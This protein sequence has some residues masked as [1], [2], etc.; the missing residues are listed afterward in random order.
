MQEGSTKTS[1]DGRRQFKLT[2][3]IGLGGFGEVYLAEMSTSSGFTKTVALKLLRSD[4]EGAGDNAR[5]MRDEA[6][7][8]GL[9]RHRAIVQADDLITV[10][11][12][13]AVIME[14]I[15]GANLSDILDPARFP[16]AVPLGLGLEVVAELADAMDAAWSRPSEITGKPLEVLHRDIKPG[17]VR[18][19]PDGSVKILDF[20]IARADQMDRETA[21]RDYAVGSLPYMAPELLMGKGASPASDMYALGV[22]LLEVMSRK[23]FGIALDTEEGHLARL[24]ERLAELDLAE[25]ASHR[26]D[27]LTLIREMLA[28]EPSQRAAA[29]KVAEQMRALDRKSVV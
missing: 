27:V 1:S 17:N 10:E 19:T 3:R 2:R 21:T 22:T 4:V 28:F 24:D 25:L 12:R 11:G 26:D 16:H 8:L 9:L 15:P 18:I 6:R 23:R 5:R 13:T 29:R 7:L 20:G 14:Y